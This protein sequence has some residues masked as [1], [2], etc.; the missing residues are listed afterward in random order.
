M[1]SSPSP[2]RRVERGTPAARAHALARP[3]ALR[4]YDAPRARPA[5]RARRALAGLGCL[6][7]ALVAASALAQQERRFDG[8][9]RIVAVADVHGAYD[10]LTALL[11]AAGLVDAELAWTGGETHL[12][13]LGDLV[14]RGPRSRDVMDLLMRLQNEAEAAGGRVHV[15]LGNHEVMNLLGDLR[16]VSSAEYAAFADSEPAGLRDAARARLTAAAPDVAEDELARRYPPGYY[17]HRAA[18]GPEGR[19]GSWLLSLP[20]LVVVNGTAFVHGGLPELVERT[21][22]QV[23]ERIRRALDDY[24]AA[25][26]AL[27]DAGVLPP[28][29]ALPDIELAQRTAESANAGAD[30]R[31]ALEELLALAS[32]PELGAD[33][34]LWYRG[35]VQCNDLLERPVLEAALERLG[36][37]GV[38]VGHTPTGD[39]RVRA[40]HDGRLVMLDTGM[41]AEHYSGRPAALIIEGAERQVQY[42]APAERA[43]V[44]RGATLAHGATERELLEV[45]AGAPVE[46]SGAGSPR[47]RLEHA[48]QDVEAVFHAAAGGAA[49]RELAAFA[50]D[51]QLGLGLV[52]PTVA[53]AIG[54]E[55]GAVQLRFPDGVTEAERLERRLPFG[56][57]PIAPQ[58]Q[59]MYAFDLLTL[60]PGRTAETLRYRNGLS[61]LVLVGHAEAFGPRR[62]LPAALD[63]ELALPPPL[64]A[65]LRG[66]DEQT[67]ESSLGDRLAPR[68]IRALLA[69]RDALLML[70]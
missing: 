9:P 1:A 59:L 22:M 36:A 63:V 8:A 12:V 17:G 46:R 26:D 55:P 39:R 34:P 35:S 11:E 62:G 10:A 21:G 57:C 19:Y 49:D 60:N 58:V 52:P 29:A 54:G 13:S 68:Q 27:V 4:A 25:R 64:V 44:E 2:R 32:A 14:D 16:Y 51:R 5:A 66:L 31:A 3:G 69:R 42:L 40:L 23:N 48:G 61:N 47:L 53:R 33:G 43:A 45:L 50:L 56:S 37:T 6:L 28:Y 41:L 15:L 7:F 20:A 18:F 70:D 65:A 38:V 30:E 67:L 24:L